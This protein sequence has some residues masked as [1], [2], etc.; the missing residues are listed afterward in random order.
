MSLAVGRGEVLAVVGESG[1]GKSVTAM[2]LMGLLPKE[3]ARI[4]SGALTLA[5]ARF[6]LKSETLPR[7][8]RGDR[9]AMIFQEPMTSLNPVFRIGDQI[10]EVVLRHRGGT[11]AAAMD[12]ARKMLDRVGIADPGQR[13]NEYPH[14]SSGGMR[15]RVMIAMALANDPEILIADEPTTALDVTIQA[16]IL[17][18]IRDLRDDTGMGTIMITHDLGVVAEIADTVAVM[19]GG[20]VVERGPVVRV[21]DDPQHPYTIGLMSAMPQLDR[22]GGRLAIVPGTVPTIATMPGGCRFRTRCAFATKT[23]AVR[24]ALSRTGAGHEVACH[25]APLEHHVSVAEVAT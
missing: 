18:L 1:C 11:R 4:S 22:P 10:A 23:C 16:Q 21:F 19:Y 12:R 8:M 14:Q 20:Q 13:L 9:M 3:A 5:E 6:D 24:P 15:Q 2:A 17:D 25:Y 7:A